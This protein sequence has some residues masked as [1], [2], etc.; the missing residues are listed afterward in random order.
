MLTIPRLYYLET[1]IA[2]MEEAQMFV[3]PWI[4]KAKMWHMKGLLQIYES[5]D[6]SKL[7]IWKS[8]HL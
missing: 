4:E 1:A 8:M 6:I 7:I 2:S 5:I 3:P